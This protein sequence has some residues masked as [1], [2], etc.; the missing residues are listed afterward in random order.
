MDAT[1]NRLPDDPDQLKQLVAALLSEKQSLL[2][3]KKS[4]LS[5]KESLSSEKATLI[6]EK[7]SLQSELQQV[8][9]K[10]LRFEEQQRLLLAKRFGASSEKSP[11]IA[12]FN[13]AEALLQEEAAIADDAI[14][15]AEDEEPISVPAHQ[16]RK[17][18]RVAIPEDLVRQDIIHELPEKDRVCSCGCTLTEIGQETSEQID[19]RPP[20]IRVLRHIR[21][22][23]ACKHCEEGALKTAPKPPQPIERSNAAPGLLAYIATAKFCDALPLYRQSTIFERFGVKIPRATLANW[24]IRSSERLQPLLNLIQEQ[25]HSYDILQMDETKIQVLKEPGKAAQTDSYMWVQQGGPPGKSAVLYHYA[26][27]RGST[28]PAALLKGYRGYLQTDGYAG[29]SPVLDDKEKNIVGL[30]CWAHARRKFIDAQKATGKGKRSRADT[31]I[32]LIGKLYKLEKQIRH[33][34]AE[35]KTRI[36]QERAKPQLEKIKSWLDETLPK[37]VPKST[38]GKA[39]HYLAGQWKRLTIYIEDGRLEIDNNGIE[40]SIRPFAVGRKNRLFANSQAGAKASAT[41][42]SLIETAKLH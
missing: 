40:R 11:Q 39:L 34:P 1:Q 12:L 31:A 29:Y 28:V 2:S 9:L 5:E 42:Y 33:L 23:Y 19:V 10:L 38:L 7:Q 18:G 6:V 24:M 37:V 14:T 30:G 27:S 35:E 8:R 41:L 36:R 26:P 25:L 16:R 32:H 3:E 4:L 21:K 20:E 15:Q 22:K 17:R 13:E